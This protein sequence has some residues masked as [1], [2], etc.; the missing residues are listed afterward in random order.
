MQT[1]S[2]PLLTSHAHTPIARSSAAQATIT[3]KYD[4][5]RDLIVSENDSVEGFY[6]RTFKRV[7]K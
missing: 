3:Q 1:C 2:A 4:A 6:I 5:E 7:R